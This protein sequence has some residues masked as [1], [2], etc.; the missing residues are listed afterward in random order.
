ML[1]VAL[2]MRGVLVRDPVRAGL[3][4]AAG[5]CLSV[6]IGLEAVPLL[7]VLIGALVVVSVSAGGREVL[8]MQAMGA[9]LFVMPPVLAMLLLGPQN[10]LAG[11]C[12]AFSAVWIAI[13]MASGI[14]LCGVPLFWRRS[15]QA[16]VRSFM[17]RLLSLAVPGV[18][19]F[20]AVLWTWPE[21]M[22]GPY[23]MIDAAARDFWLTGVPQEASFLQ[24]FTFSAGLVFAGLMVAMATAA[25]AAFLPALRAFREGK[26]DILILW[27]VACVSVV[28][29][30]VQTRYIRFPFFMVAVF[31]PLAVFTL[32]SGVRA[33]ASRLAGAATA[34]VL[35]L[36]GSAYAFSGN[37]GLVIRES[38]Y[39]AADSCKAADYSVVRDIPPSRILAPFGLTYGIVDQHAG[40]RLLAMEFHRAAPGISKMARISMARQFIYHMHGLSK[41][42][43]NKKVLDNVN[44][45]VFTRM[46]RSASSG[47]NGAGK[48]TLLRIMAGL[49]KEF[50]GEAWA[51]RGR[52]GRL[53]AAGAAARRGAKNV[54]GNVM[55]GVADKKAK[56]DRYNELMMNYSD[57]TAD[58]SAQL[59]DEIDAQN[60]WDL[61]SQVEMAM[62][63]LR[64]PPGDATVDNLS[65][66]ER[67]V[68]RSASLLLS[69]P[70]A[71]A[72]RADQP[73]R[74]R[75]RSP[76]WS[77]FARISRL[78]PDDHPRPLLPR[79]R[80]R[81]D[82]RARPRPRHSLR[83]QL[84]RLSGGRR[85]SAWSRKGREEDMPASARCHR[86]QEWI[87][88]SSPKARQAK[89]KA[90]IRAY[91]ELAEA[92]RRCR[93][94]DAQIVIPAGE[95]SATNVIEARGL[96]KGYGDRLL[97]DNLEFK[98]PPG[99]IV[100]VIGPNGAGKTTLF[101]MI[102]GQEQ[103][104]SGTITVGDTVN[105]S[106]V[107]QSRDALDG[108]KTVW[109]E[110][111][112]GNDIIKLGKHEVNS[113]AYCG[114]F[115]F[116]GGDQQQKVGTLSGGQRNRVHLAKLS[117]GRRQPAPARRTDQRPRHRDARRAGRGAGEIS[118]AAPWSSAMTACSSTASPPTSSPS[119]ATAMS[120]GSRATSRT[121]SRTRSAASA[122]TASIRSG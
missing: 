11:H 48:S 117:E 60:L 62:E 45:S 95:R 71:A 106:Y 13:L 27:L 88:E 103:P 3:I 20:A 77:T 31:M 29:A 87:A 17:L 80:H 26:P 37:T 36:T 74:R 38:D 91:D 6:S 119:K 16:G 102:T 34:I 98:L 94:G 40:H 73:P 24:F 9:G 108:N 12:D 92:G 57:E 78:R 76:G 93:P 43:N 52:Q 8:R 56:L 116:K 68:S 21:C 72:R 122:R 83:G 10:A 61:D 75:D 85:P 44:L 97:I 84:L 79:Q 1:A 33:G 42:Y 86:E 114:S 58:E 55:E 110:I 82:P 90:R 66:G 112:G 14:V 121:T 15:A 105:L 96:S 41:A 49:D 47:P 120:N 118:P 25:A 30:L 4:V 51:G 64:C 32:K 99:G 104:D 22:G 5:V 35:I 54:L 67:A 46:P 70:T 39:L 53:S 65:G 100:G 2:A 59:Q 19:A 89:S 111:S 107:D 81:L 115:N 63:A 109:E 69:S 23:H 113:R 101:R 28:L 50:T 7:F 18:A